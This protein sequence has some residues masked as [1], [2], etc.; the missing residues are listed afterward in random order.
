MKMGD[1]I[2]HLFTRSD[3]KNQNPFN[4][5]LFFGDFCLN[6]FGVKQSNRR[7]LITELRVRVKQI[8]KIKVPMYVL[9]CLQYR[10]ANTFILSN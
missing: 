1:V 9:M 6:V 10:Q 4:F 2:L 5:R 3:L 8:A 7:V